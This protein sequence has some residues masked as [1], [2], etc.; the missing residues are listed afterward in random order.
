MELIENVISEWYKA[1]YSN[2]ELG[3]ILLYLFCRGDLDGDAG[4][5]SRHS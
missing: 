4:E 5:D 2:L 3:Y 1:G